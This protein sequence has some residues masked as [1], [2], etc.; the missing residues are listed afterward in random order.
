MPDTSA[1][2]PTS[3]LA[4]PTTADLLELISE[5]RRELDELRRRVERAEAARPGDADR[6]VVVP[7]SA[8]TTSTEPVATETPT[9]HH[10]ADAS[11]DAG[12]SSRRQMLR[13]VGTVAAGAAV[14]A[15]LLAGRP[16]AAATGDP[17]V[18]GAQNTGDRT[19][20][21]FS[22][23]A[24]EN[25]SVLG[26]ADAP[27]EIDVEA[28]IAGMA[29]GAD[30]GVNRVYNGVVGYAETADTNVENGHALIAQ[31][32]P[33]P[34]KVAPRSNLW[35][36]PQLD[37]PRVDTKEHTVGEIVSDTDGDIWHCVQRGTPGVW[38]RL[39]GFS[40]NGAFA[41][42]APTR[43]YDT[44]LPGGGGR[45]VPGNQRIVSVAD[46][47]N[48]ET[49]QVNDRDVVPPGATAVAYNLAVANAEGRGFLFLAPADIVGVSG[50]SINW[51]ST[52]GQVNN[53]SVV[54]LAGDRQ[55]RITCGDQGGTAEVI[56]DVVGYYL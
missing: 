14:A 30:S 48:E 1:S 36:R 6:S 23:I 27:K 26:V 22:P 2:A 49:G 45:Y 29:T 43:V 32:Q 13:R 31:A 54:G 50:A 18:T 51:T 25:T 16:A 24:E 35:L 55:I 21:L 47:I 33:T 37:D 3:T 17:F 44:R 34:G 20:L 8:A 53:G 5:Q 52:T 10:V 28:A 19:T 38:R 7:L 4:T 12:G 9:G 41:A 39:S 56:V 40:T 46:S 11:A 15:P 42:I